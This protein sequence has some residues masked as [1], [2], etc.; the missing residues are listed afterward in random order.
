M[1]QIIVT[2]SFNNSNLPISQ[3]GSV[4]NLPSSLATYEMQDSYDYSEKGNNLVL[5]PGLSFDRLGLVCSGVE[6]D[7]ADTGILEPDSYTV[8]TAFNANVPPATTQLWTTLGTGVTPY[9]GARQALRTT[10][11][12]NSQAFGG[13]GSTAASANLVS[14][15]LANMW[16][17]YAFTLTN[18]NMRTYRGSSA[19]FTEAP[20]LN[21]RRK[22]ITPLRIA[23]GYVAPHNIGISG[24]IGFL[25]VY[26]GVLTDTQITDLVAKGKAMLIERG[27]NFTW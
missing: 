9:N 24:H 22:S 3:V 15:A 17:I 12:L 5:T 26:D 21:N 25:S 8:L 14:G 19:T 11:E 23:G 18:T 16:E 7:Y 4:L 13:D 10:G 27:A 1:L 2:D 20:V 6:G